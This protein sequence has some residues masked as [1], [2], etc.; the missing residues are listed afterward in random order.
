MEFWTPTSRPLAWNA[1][2]DL[3]GVGCIILVKNHVIP[4]LAIM[5]AL[6]GF[7]FAVLTLLF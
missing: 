5:M 1:V 3:M 4:M 2:L 6:F 7:H